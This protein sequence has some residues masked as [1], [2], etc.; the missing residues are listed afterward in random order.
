ML[1]V[2]IIGY[3]Y[4]G[5]NLVRNFITSEETRVVMVCDRSRPRLDKVRQLYPS[6]S[7]TQSPDELFNDGAVD[8]V[9]IA[10]PVEMHFD[11]AMAALKAGANAC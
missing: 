4:W 3:G 11:S 1:N 8:A 9:V 7:L 5:P 10:T 6:M 2:G